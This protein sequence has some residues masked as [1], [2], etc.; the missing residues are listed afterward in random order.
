MNFPNLFEWK[1]FYTTHPNF[2]YCIRRGDGVLTHNF[3]TH[4]FKDFKQ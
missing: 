3:L 1:E 2:A 4:Y